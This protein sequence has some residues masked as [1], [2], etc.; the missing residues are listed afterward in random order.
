MGG[1]CPL[2]SNMQT[3]AITTKFHN[4]QMQGKVLHW[5]WKHGTRSSIVHFAFSRTPVHTQP[6]SY[7]KQENC[8][9]S[10]IRYR[11]PPGGHQLL[12]RLYVIYFVPPN[13][14]RVVTPS[15]HIPKLHWGVWTRCMYKVG[16]RGFLVM[17]CYGHSQ[18]APLLLKQ[19][20]NYCV[21]P[22][23]NWFSS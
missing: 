15:S 18:V 6:R 23:G 1:C 8:Y 7:T 21:R 4:W 9:F 3:A 19:E 2:H 12:Q 22:L 10:C 13:E 14:C 11:L 16:E 17:Q 20:S 5:F